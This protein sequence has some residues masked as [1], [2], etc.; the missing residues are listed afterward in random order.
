MK[1]G[2]IASVV[3][4]CALIC[5][6]VRAQQP[7]ETIRS[8]FIEMLSAA[9]TALQPQTAFGAARAANDAEAAK[10]AASSSWSQLVGQRSGRRCS[11]SR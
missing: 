7:I 3:V 10:D 1:Y 5:G 9:N 2:F 6:P 8:D 4:A 11:S